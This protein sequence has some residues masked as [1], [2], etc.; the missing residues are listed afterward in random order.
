MYGAQGE[1]AVKCA[2]ADTVFLEIQ[3]HGHVSVYV[4]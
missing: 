2:A 4:W 1:V 3:V